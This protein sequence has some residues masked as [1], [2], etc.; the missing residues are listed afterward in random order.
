MLLIITN[1]HDLACDYL[2]VRL[3]ERGIPFGRLN[4]DQYTESVSVDIALDEDNLSYVIRLENNREVY[5]ADVTAVYFRQPITPSFKAAANGV[6]RA[7]AE[8][9]LT[10]TLRSLWRVIPEELWLNHPK[11]LWLASNKVE[12]LI[13]AKEVGF[14]IPDTLISFSPERIRAFFE[15]HDGRV[16][17]KAVKHGF[18][19]S[20]DDLLLAGTQQLPRDFVDH[21]NEFARIPMTFQEEIDKEEEVRAIVVGERVF[22]TRILVGGQDS[23]TIDWRVAELTGANLI[24]EQISLPLHVEQKC[25]SI[26]QYFGLKYSSMDIVKDRQGRFIFLELNPNGQWGWIEQI[27]GYPIRDQI[28]DTLWQFD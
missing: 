10:E 5:P 21:I 12:Q 25:L 19:R 14:Q 15:Q 26:V 2:I 16:I 1:R 3:R 23:S 20:D 22:A 18:I 11:K 8:A 17:A 27:V 28:I 13:A 7:F 6:D 9:E 4:T 24:H